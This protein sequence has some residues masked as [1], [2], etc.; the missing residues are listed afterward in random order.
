MRPAIVALLLAFFAAAQL[1]WCDG[2]ALI[3]HQRTGAMSV[4]LFASPAPARAGMTDFSVLLQDAETQDV[5]LDG[6]I[7]LQL[8]KAGMSPIEADATTGQATN[9]LLY[10]AAV[11]VPSAGAWTITVRCRVHG[12]EE[13]AS[14]TL[15]V[16]APEPPLVSYWPYFAVVPVAI[17]LFIFNQKLKSRRRSAR[18]PVRP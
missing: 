7:K 10:A 4:S 11:D 18:L 13:S 5:L 16:L 6:T 3:L 17:F 15:A 2:G 9:K 12:K 8:T 14:G 1:S